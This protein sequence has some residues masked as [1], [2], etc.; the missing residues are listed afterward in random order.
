MADPILPIY[1]WI[2][3]ACCGVFASFMLNGFFTR[4]RRDRIIADTPLVRIRSAAQGFVRFEG[5][6][7]PPPGENMMAPLSGLPCVWWDYQIAERQTNSKGDTEYDIVD[8]G[9]S[10]ATFTLS[11]ADGECLIGPVGAEITPTSTDVWYGANPQPS[12]PPPQTHAVFTLSSARD[13]RYIERRIAIGAHLSVAGELRSQ[14]AA[15]VV[16]QTTHGDPF[17]IAPL[18]G[19]HLVRREKRSAMLSLVAS[20]LFLALCVWALAKA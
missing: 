15:R 4:L 7:G 10:V 16:G 1:Y 20:V 19:E 12:G 8:E 9:S 18:D 3:A 11:D 6:A 14:M 5:R 13:Y 17:L 2:F